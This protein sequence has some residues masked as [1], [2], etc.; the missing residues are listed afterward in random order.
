MYGLAVKSRPAPSQFDTDRRIHYTYRIGRKRISNEA[1][2]Q[3]MADNFPKSKR[4]N[5]AFELHNSSEFYRV[6]VL[7]NLLISKARKP[8]RWMIRK[9]PPLRRSVRRG[10]QIH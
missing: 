10:L 8:Q 6:S 3:H 5:V 2:S 7:K 4:E 1:S 9:G